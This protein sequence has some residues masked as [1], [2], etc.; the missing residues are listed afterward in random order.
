MNRGFGNENPSGN[1]PEMNRRNELEMNQ[2]GVKMNHKK[3]VEMKPKTIK[4]KK[5]KK[6]IRTG[7]DT[8]NQ[9]N[10]IKDTVQKGYRGYIVSIKIVTDEEA[11][12]VIYTLKKDF[13]SV[14]NIGRF[15]VRENII[16]VQLDTN[17]TLCAL[18]F[19]DK[20]VFERVV[21]RLKEFD[22]EIVN[23]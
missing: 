17:G 19:T 5:P 23:L 3:D 16:E 8:M 20:K 15:I 13:M 22:V 6:Q 7:D 12:T 11:D 21:E 10:R 1:E 4:F 18:Y 9:I 2:R 14:K